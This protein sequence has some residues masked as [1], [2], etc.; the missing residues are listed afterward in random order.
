[1]THP[2]QWVDDMAVAGANIF[3]FHVEVNDGGDHTELIN[4]IKEKMKVG[5][6]IKPAPRWIVC[7][8]ICP[9]WTLFSS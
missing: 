2:Q 4:K 9:F 7:T 8:L 6:A 3:T 5:L 1:M